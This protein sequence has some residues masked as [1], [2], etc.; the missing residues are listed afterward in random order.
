MASTATLQGAHDALLPRAPGGNGAGAALA[1]LVHVAL[2][3]AL[4]TAVDWR[5]KTPEVFSAELWANVPQ[6][7]APAATDAAASS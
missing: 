4:T 3:L 6:I 2:L 7:A 5:A 1:L